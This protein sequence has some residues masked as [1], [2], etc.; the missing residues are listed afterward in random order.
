MTVRNELLKNIR[1]EEHYDKGEQNQ[2]R[3]VKL[4]TKENI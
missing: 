2:N 1:Q 4:N 3:V